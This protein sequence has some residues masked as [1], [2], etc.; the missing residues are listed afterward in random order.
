MNV[1]SFPHPLELELTIQT[2]FNPKGLFEV[3]PCLDKD[4]V[5]YPSQP[6]DKCTGTVKVQ[7]VYSHTVHHFLSHS[8]SLTVTQHTTHCHVAHHSLS[9]ST[10]LTVT[11]HTTHCHTAHHSLSHSTPLTVTQHIT[12]CHTAHHSLSHS[13][14]LSVTQHTTHCH[15]AHHSL[16]HSTPLTVTQH[17]THCHTAHPNVLS[18]NIYVIYCLFINCFLV[19]LITSCF[20]FILCPFPVHV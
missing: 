12:H 20:C 10:P 3:T 15:T 5:F 13:T 16:S 18:C 14:P 1:F 2:S 4:V 17:T 19:P 11:Q 9:H 8:T 6:A 7:V